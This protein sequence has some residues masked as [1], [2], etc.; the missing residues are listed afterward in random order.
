MGAPKQLRGQVN[1]LE[2]LHDPLLFIL[3]PC[4]AMLKAYSCVCTQGPFLAGPRGH[5]GCWRLNHGLLMHGKCPLHCAVL[6]EKSL[7]SHL[8]IQTGPRASSRPLCC[9]LSCMTFYNGLIVPFQNTGGLQNPVS[10]ASPLGS[11]SESYRDGQSLGHH[12]YP[13][14]MSTPRAEE[15]EDHCDTWCFPQSL[16]SAPELQGSP[17]YSRTPIP[18]L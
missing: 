18:A 2:I 7:G 11:C 5:I 10:P 3:E 4:P 6:L 16:L 13:L 15:G 12:H 14:Q 1:S 9:P 8:I 17:L